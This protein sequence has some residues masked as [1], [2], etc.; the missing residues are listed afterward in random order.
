VDDS[1]S[2][3][4]LTRR[5]SKLLSTRYKPA[6]SLGLTS[7]VCK[8]L[9]AGPMLRSSASRS[10]FR[11]LVS[12]TGPHLRPVHHR[13]ALQT[14]KLWTQ[15]THRPQLVI[16]TVR[17]PVSAFLVRHQ[18]TQWTIDRKH[19]AE[20]GQQ[21]LKPDPKDVTPTSSVHPVLHEAKASDPHGDT[22][23]MAGIKGDLVSLSPPILSTS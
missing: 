8:E 9:E 15:T 22:D 18:T 19:E 20:I 10:L 14:S 16:N 17:K 3:V 2:Q 5:A 1:C 6:N 11:T 23:M 4:Q 13:G 12:S 21:K 7:S